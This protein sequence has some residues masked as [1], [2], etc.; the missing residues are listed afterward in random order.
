MEDAKTVL[1][2]KGCRGRG[3]QIPKQ[4]SECVKG[5]GPHPGPDTLP[6]R[7]WES[8]LTS[9][10]PSLF[11][12]KPGTLIVG[13]RS[14]PQAQWGTAGRWNQVV[15]PLCRPRLCIAR[16]GRPFTGWFQSPLLH[17]SVLS[18]PFSFHPRL[19]FCGIVFTFLFISYLTGQ[20]RE[21]PRDISLS[22]VNVVTFTLQ[23][24]G[25]IK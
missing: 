15:S 7:P 3:A 8:H 17:L 14:L 5:A 13:H 11:T 9:L 21:S 19:A 2:S 1:W 20:S 6:A 22:A 4:G 16:A 10:S 24:S 25:E 18:A 23:D 12:C